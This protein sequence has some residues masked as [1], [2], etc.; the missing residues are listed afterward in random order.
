M[1]PYKTIIKLN[2]LAKQTLY[3]QLTNQFITL[4]KNGSLPSKTK[5]PG[6][7]TLSQLINVHRKTVVACYEELTLQGWV[8]SIPQKGTFVNENIPVLQ[9]Q[10]LGEVVK[11]VKQD[12][13]GFS[14][15]INKILNRTFPQHFDDTFMYVN[16]GVSDVRLAPTKEITM[17]YKK[18][19][20]KKSSINELG[21][22]TTYGND[23]LRET[24]VTYLNETRGLNITKDHIIIT[25]GS[26]MG[27]FLAAQLLVSDNDYIITGETNYS[28]S[29]TTFEFAGA[30]LLR[31]PVDEHGLSTVA[32][33]H[34]CEK[35]SIKAIYTTPH[36]HHPTTVTMSAER[37]IHLL[38][39]AKRY[40][41]AII[42]DDYD[43]DFHYNHAPILPLA[44][45]DKNGNVIYVGSVC[46]AIA[47]VY[48]VGY[49]VASKDFVDECAKL[50]RFVDRQGDALLELAFADFIKSG[51]LD[52]HIKKVVKL[53][54]VR[55][56]LFCRFLKSELG[57]YFSFEVPKGGMAVWVTLNKPLSW[58]SV[59]KIAETQ[60][61]I[62]PEWQRYD[63]AK[64][65][66]NA[67]RIGFAAYNE[68][69]IQELINRLK[70]TIKI[71]NN[72]ID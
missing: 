13:S 29:D 61:L 44:S 31:V 35:H 42:E 52:R 46:K 28:S 41:F 67:I 65:G 69:E 5:L 25:R 26:Q 40:K 30:R 47:P 62:I 36:H 71:I 51:N 17:L 57:D 32:V 8:E 63:M 38:N 4:I 19:A 70:Q 2:R 48:R 68:T 59:S 43:Y 58:E 53:Y 16:D 55:R 14:F 22:G 24:L 21:Y 27:M 12:I 18:W 39:L 1:F 9:Q 64:T 56:D 33:E 3:L 50:R 6:S 15:T 20:N 34:L 11:E 66:H 10:K 7:R 54:K 37:R 49:L 23:L 60:K 45:H 72:Q